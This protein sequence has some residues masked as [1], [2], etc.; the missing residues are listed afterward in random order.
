[1][2]QNLDA[3]TERFEKSLKVLMQNFGPQLIK[4]TQTDLTPGQVFML[5][6]IQQD[7]LCSVTKL[8]DTLE[9]S[10]S[11]ITV[12]LDRLEDH[13][14]VRRIRDDGDRRMVHIEL[15]KTGRDHMMN[16][17]N[18]RDH[19]MK[20]CFSQMSSGE[21]HSL[22]YSLEKLANIAEL[23]DTEAMISSY[24]KEQNA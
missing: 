24:K 20:H 1:M 17:L 2:D 5:H 9:V 22:I 18:V 21:L 4:R 12:M 3:L 13:G 10:P 7:R 8:A 23:T 16:V 19:V 14:Y 15:T 6:V 11:A